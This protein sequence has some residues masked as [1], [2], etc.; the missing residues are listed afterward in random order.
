MHNSVESE[1]QT[2]V[3]NS[4]AAGLNIY[5]YIYIYNYNYYIYIIYIYIYNIYNNNYIPRYYG[6]PL[7]S[8]FRAFQYFILFLYLFLFYILS[9]VIWKYYPINRN[10]VLIA[11]CFLNKH[12]V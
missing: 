10:T 11:T 4:I 8:K 7:P 2:A 1:A 3:G 12:V 5:M 9:L 6:T